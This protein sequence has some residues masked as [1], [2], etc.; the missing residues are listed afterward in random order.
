M[1]MRTILAE[2]PHVSLWTPNWMEAA[3]VTSMEPLRIDPDHLRERMSDSAIRADLMAYG[4]GE[5]E[6]LLAT[7]VT[8]DVEL[9][10]YVGRRRSSTTISPGSNSSTSILPSGRY[11]MVTSCRFGSPLPHT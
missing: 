4:L 6:Q 2:S 1:M 7:F 10:A 8:A 11:A 9:A 5:P 3:D